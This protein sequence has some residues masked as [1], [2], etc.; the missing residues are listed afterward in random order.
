VVGLADVA[1]SVGVSESTASRA[2]NRPELVRSE[3][4]ERVREAAERLGYVPN[5]FARSLRVQGS[6]TLGLIIPDSTNS[7]FAEVAKG[8]EEA[9]FRAGYTLILGNS[10]RSLEKEAA[11]AQVF[12]EQRV[13]GVLLFNTNDNSAETMQRLLDRA[14]PVV[15]VERRSPGPP[16][17]AVLSDN[18][19]AI[20]AAIEHLV[21]LGHRRIAFLVG[22]ITASHYAERLS[23]Y[24]EMLRVLGLASD[25]EL[26]RTDVVSYADGQAA[27]ESLFRLAGPPTAL[28]CATDTLAIG[29]L[30]GLATMGLQVPDDVAVIGYGDTEISAYTTPSLTTVGQQKHL[31]GATAVEILLRRLHALRGEVSPP[32]TRVIPT[33]L[34]IRESTAGPGGAEEHA[35]D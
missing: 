35:H 3:V 33:T 17:D 20:R 2:L 34:V 22:D 9:C 18:R 4:V 11:Q 5:P 1:R 28:L 8:I 7:F 13:D 16:V 27:S 15:L 29:A 23:A 12:Y 31:V 10:D 30:R 21:D 32:H 26:V 24:Q 19:A 14:V 25:R 6:K